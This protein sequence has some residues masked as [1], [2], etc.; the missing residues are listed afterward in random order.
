MAGG[1]PCRYRAAA[2][3]AASSAL[4]GNTDGRDAVSEAL[5]PLVAPL[6]NLVALLLALSFRRNRAFLVLLPL[7]LAAAAL[8][9]YP[10]PV[11]GRED[12]AQMFS[13]W[14]L[15]AAAALPERGLLARGNLLLL[16]A[17]TIAVWLVFAAPAHVWSALHRSLPLGVLPCSAAASAAGLVVI[18]GGACALRGA[19]R[20]GPM[21]GGLA[22]VLACAALALSPFAHGNSAIAALT[23]AGVLAVLAIL[24]ASF[25]MAFIDTLSG[26]PNRRA[27]DEALTRLSGDY[28]V[29]MVDIDHF[30]R[31]NDTHGHAAGDL[32]LKAV[33]AQLRAIRG[34]RAFRFGGEEFCVLFGSAHARAA[35]ACE[36][37]RQRVEQSRVRIRSVPNPRRRTQAVRRDQAN[38]VRVTISIGLAERDAVARTPEEV[39]KTADQ[40]LYRAKA[41]GRNGIVI[42]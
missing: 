15:L 22:I 33:A 40:A 39:L 37:A 16:F 31:F 28:A 19:L 38:D 36:A 21:E 1:R 24:Y 7:T 5:P 35:E 17:T 10:A 42:A 2:S 3:G 13:P 23:V 32:V 34:G 9:G 30:K 18:A 25:R 4:A 14:L 20:G 6:V 11:A 26:L 8:T 41:S 29:A 27:L 12:A